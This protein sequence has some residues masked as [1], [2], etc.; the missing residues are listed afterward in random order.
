MWVKRELS[1]TLNSEK[2]V[3]PS[4]TQPSLPP[5]LL[6]CV[7]S[8]SN[9]CQRNR[10]SRG[11]YPHQV[12]SCPYQKRGHHRVSNWKCSWQK[13]QGRIL[14]GSILFWQGVAE[15]EA[16]EFQWIIY[17]NSRAWLI[18]HSLFKSV[19]GCQHSLLRSHLRCGSINSFSFF[20][21]DDIL[22]PLC[23]E[24]PLQ[25]CE[26]FSKRRCGLS[27]LLLQESYQWNWP[28]QNLHFLF[29][30]WCG[31]LLKSSLDLLKHCFCFMLCLL[32]AFSSQGMWD[33]SSPTRIKPAPHA[34]E[35]KVPSSEPPGKPP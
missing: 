10:C 13:A 7:S 21:N 34:L 20:F 22:E 6:E 33:L 15:G 5:C 35:S 4:Q 2:H 1:W 30:F 17:I 18:W 24:Q 26:P 19:R 32:F 9:A 29:F 3:P 12:S 27:V 25:P 11:I 14:Q 16:R 8:R 23:R 28:G 31:P